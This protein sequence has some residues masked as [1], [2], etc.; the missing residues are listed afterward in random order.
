MLYIRN[1]FKTHGVIQ[2]YQ[3]KRK[4]RS[5]PRKQK[6]K[7][8]RGAILISNKIEVRSKTIKMTKNIF[9]Y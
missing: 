7:E 3:N 5:F 9:Q 8:N 6:Q 1:K 4:D 2:N